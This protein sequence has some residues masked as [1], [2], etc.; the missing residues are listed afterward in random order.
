MRTLV[1]VA[2]I[3]FWA[4]LTTLLLLQMTAPE[5]PVPPPG[6]T[7]SAAV[8]AAATPPTE[9]GE[10]RYT[11][12]EVA[13]H[14]RREDCWMAIDGA[15]Y[16]LSAYIDRHPGPETLLPPWCGRDASEGMHTKGLGRDHSARAWRAL[17]RYRIGTLDVVDAPEAAGR[18]ME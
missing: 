10:P 11:L 18:T 3:A 6:S 5:D 9:E 2:F 12:D 1:Q 15:V 4:A 8:T 13:R 14:D 16:D 7:P 17:E